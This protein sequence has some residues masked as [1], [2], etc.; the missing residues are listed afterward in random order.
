MK[1]IKKIELLTKVQ[2]QLR[3]GWTQGALARQADGT[4]T[5][6]HD[7]KAVAWSLPGA[8]MLV[9]HHD[10][11]PARE[12]GLRRA[13]GFH[14]GEFITA[15]NDNPER[16]QEEIISMIDDLI[17][18]MKVNYLEIGEYALEMVVSFVDRK[19]REQAHE[20]ADT[21]WVLDGLDKI[22]SHAK[23]AHYWEIPKKKGGD[24]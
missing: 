3:K 2:E 12:R 5:F 24:N 22:A 4:P 9:T 21:E 13:I 20:N 16:T 14:I 6:T 10:A 8:C 7:D 15:Y 23:A 1:S 17:K 11:H 18:S 19:N